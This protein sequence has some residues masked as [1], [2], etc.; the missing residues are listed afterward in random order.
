MRSRLADATADA[1]VAPLRSA[2]TS[3]RTR[4][5]EGILVD[6]WER[7]RSECDERKF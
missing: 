4:L 1:V 2:A 3:G 5:E 7:M 6:G